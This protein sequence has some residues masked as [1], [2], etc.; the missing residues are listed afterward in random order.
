MRVTE[1]WF[2]LVA[3]AP[4]KLG[5]LKGDADKG[6]SQFIRQASTEKANKVSS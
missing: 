3:K 4:E 5:Y 2:A 1:E 6:V